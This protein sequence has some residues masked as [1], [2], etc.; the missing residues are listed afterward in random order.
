MRRCH[1]QARPSRV[2]PTI[3][4]THPPHCALQA[5]KYLRLAWRSGRLANICDIII[6]Q[7]TRDRLHN[8][9]IAAPEFDVVYAGLMQEGR[10]GRAL[11]LLNVS[12]KRRC[13]CGN[14]G[15]RLPHSM[16]RQAMELHCVCPFLLCAAVFGG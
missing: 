7:R 5:A 2:S 4:F 12:S 8:K 6:E 13:A 11:A 9:R 15:Q 16:W 1:T 3:P 14:F 10:I